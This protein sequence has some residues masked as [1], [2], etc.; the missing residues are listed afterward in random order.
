MVELN[1]TNRITLLEDD[2]TFHQKLY[3]IGML[4]PLWS[5]SF[6]K[7][8]TP[9]IQQLWKICA[10]IATFVWVLTIGWIF[11]L[12]GYLISRIK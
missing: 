5:F 1:I 2:E 4:T 12:F 9:S 10:V 8:E 3:T 6:I 7:F 11:L